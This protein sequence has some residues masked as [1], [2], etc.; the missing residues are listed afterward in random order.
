M[1][2]KTISLAVYGD[3]MKALRHTKVPEGAMMPKRNHVSTVYIYIQN[4]FDL[5]L[6]LYQ[7]VYAATSIA[8]N[9]SQYYQ[10]HSI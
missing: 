7:N 9:Y 3:K 2:D 8:L 10:L 5:Y 4:S 6:T 1:H